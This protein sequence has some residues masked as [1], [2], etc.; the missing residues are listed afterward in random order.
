MITM[1]KYHY[2][3][4]ISMCSRVGMRLVFICAIGCLLITDLC[5]AKEIH[6]SGL[7]LR[8]RVSGATTLGDPQPEVFQEYD[9]A[10]HFEL[11]WDI[12]SGSGW[13]LGTKLMASAGILRGTGENGLV[14]SLVPGFICASNDGRFSVDAGAG[15]ALLSRYEFGSQDYGGPFQF[16]LTV[17]AGLP[18]Y[19]RFGLGYRFMHYSDAAINGSDTTGADFH[20]VEI[21]Y[22]L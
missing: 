3:C 13:N 17:G 19:K 15:F 6:L 18:L 21:A 2:S 16:A 7:S 14:A 1:A 10:T 5:Y 8:A 22:R 9:L 20:M 4:Y 12:Y 11:P